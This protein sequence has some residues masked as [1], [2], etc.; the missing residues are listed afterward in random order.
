MNDA[1]RRRLLSPILLGVAGHTRLR[2]EDRSALEATARG[3][4]EQLR[5]RYP[6]TPLT[7]V[8][9]LAE[10]GD[11]LCAEIALELG[12]DVIA[13]L[14]FPVELYATRFKT[15]AARDNLRRLAA[16]PG[17]RAFCPDAS[18]GSRPEFAKVI[19]DDRLRKQR[20]IDVAL[21]VARHAHALIALWDG[22]RTPVSL[23]A[24]IIAFKSSGQPPAG[25]EACMAAPEPGIVYYIFAPRSESTL[26]PGAIPG[27]L[28]VL[29][30]DNA[31]SAG[32]QALFDQMC[33]LTEALNA[34]VA[35]AAIPKENDLAPKPPAASPVANDLA[36]FRRLVANESYRCKAHVTWAYATVFILVFMGAALLHSYGHDFDLVNGEPEYKA[37]LFYASL[38]CFALAAGF[39]R[40]FKTL[41][42]ENRALD[43]R[44]LAEAL[45]VQFHWRRA[46]LAKWV[47]DHYLQRQRS[48]LAWIRGAT[49]AWALRLQAEGAPAASD[50]ERI[51]AVASKW[52][53]E[54]SKF[55]HKSHRQ[56]EAGHH[57]W[58][59]ASFACLG[60]AV[61]L[62]AI[63]LCGQWTGGSFSVAHP[64]HHPMP[65]L[66][67]IGLALL[68]AAMTLAYG[69]K[70][71]FAEHARHSRAME[72]LFL[73][74]KTRAERD[75]RAGRV[76]AARALLQKMGEES[77]EE[78][79][80][81]LILHRVR[82][83]EVPAAG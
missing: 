78:N 62:G 47:A 8:S 77:L 22:E 58:R 59:R 61:A 49:R 71:L 33:T 52:F 67:L 64:P 60:L 82:H 50:A 74:A 45:R 80:E 2:D 44:A 41:R 1:E 57:F 4:F 40:V 54:Q 14:P 35:R 38:I 19:A 73:D 20:Y 10:G 75:L 69:E 81:W 7:L 39:P 37:G 9:S 55:H 48:E 34:R 36:A 5:R 72:A 26:H 12:C 32:M 65:F 15:P 24:Q 21:L 27:T 56:N 17:V 83:F 3:V 6:C 42:S 66:E 28:K 46:G 53:E 18:D 76:E 63:L 11:Q 70:R 30:G 51:G 31:A 16:H 29:D 68:A 43:Y 79:T 23:T 25:S 13:P